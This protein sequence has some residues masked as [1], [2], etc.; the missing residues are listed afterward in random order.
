VKHF[1]AVLG[2]QANRV[3]ALAPGVVATE[4]SS[5]AKTEEGRD[6]TTSMQALKRHVVSLKVLLEP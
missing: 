3:N 5:F 2:P 4:M 1:A 6:A